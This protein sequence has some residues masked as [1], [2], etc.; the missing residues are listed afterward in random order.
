MVET[1]VETGPSLGVSCRASVIV[2]A[3]VGFGEKLL[4]PPVCG[5][6]FPGAQEKHHGFVKTIGKQ[7]ELSESNDN[8]RG[9]ADL[10]FQGGIGLPGLFELAVR[11]EH[12]GSL[13]VGCG[14][15]RSGAQDGERQKYIDQHLADLRFAAN[16]RGSRQRN[17]QMET[18]RRKSRNRCGTRSKNLTSS[19]LHRLRVPGLATS[20]TAC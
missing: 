15:R 17:G 1:P 18:R 7:G 12:F 14:N 9:L 19:R 11:E 10:S 20:L 3:I 4:A 8:F 5:F 2:L 13:P 6:K 16:P